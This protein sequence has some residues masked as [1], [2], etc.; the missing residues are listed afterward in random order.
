MTEALFDRDGEYYIP[1]ELSRGPWT[2]DALHGG[3]VAALVAH[4]ADAAE[5]RGPMHPARLTLELLRPVP[6]APLHASV[7][8]LRPGKK[9]QVVEAS[10]HAED[11]EVARGTLLR[12]RT[13]STPLP[14]ET[15]G[16]DTT[17]PEGPGGVATSK[18]AWM[19]ELRAYHSHAT[20]HRVVRGSW[21]RIGPCTDWVRVRVPLFEGVPLSPFE[22]VAAAA[23]FGNGIGAALPFESFRFL[24]ADLT[25]HLHRLPVGDWV[26]LDAASYPEPAGVGVAESTL[27]DPQGRLGRALQSLLIERR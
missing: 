13:A 15:A 2:P 21:T 27:S 1:T 19:G 18:P 10:L 7:R 4:L 14:P 25:L 11:M 23:D 17:A 26:C 24:N 8:V 20:E 3:P 9:V 22:R 6:L 5:A 12:I 16:G